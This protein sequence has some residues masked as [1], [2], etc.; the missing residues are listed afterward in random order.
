MTSRSCHFL[1]SLNQLGIAESTPEGA[2]GWM[3][4]QWHEP[5]TCRAMY[6]KDFLA[7]TNRQAK[8]PATAG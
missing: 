4:E 3:H 7:E 1:P 6:L 2:N 5:R 8:S